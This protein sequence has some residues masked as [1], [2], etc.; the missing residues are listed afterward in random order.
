MK[1]CVVLSIYCL[2][3]KSSVS[4]FKKNKETIFLPCATKQWNSQMLDLVEAKTKK[5]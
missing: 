3:V 5:E 2:V 1:Y 4:G